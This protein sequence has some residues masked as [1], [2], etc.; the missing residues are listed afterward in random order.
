MQML[1][2]AL[3][4]LLFLA[5]LGALFAA[6][7]VW[8]AY[9]IT[10]AAFLMLATVIFSYLSARTL[11]THAAYRSNVVAH[12]KAID[13]FTEQN[14]QLLKGRPEPDPAD[15]KSYGINGLDRE[16]AKE[17]AARGRV[18]D[19]G[20]ANRFDPQTGVVTVVFEPQAPKVEENTVV[21][22]FD[23]KDRATQGGA[24]MGEFLVTAVGDKELQ[25]TP[26]YPLLPWQAQRIA[27]A[28][29]PWILYEIMPADNHEW[30]RELDEARLRALLPPQSLPEFLKDGK[31]AA[32]NDPPDRVWRQVKFLK[33]HEMTVD[34]VPAKFTVDQTATV[35]PKT[36]QELVQAG[37]AE[38]VGQV[39]VRELRSYAQLFRELRQDIQVLSDT[40]RELTD[41]VARIQTAWD[42]VKEDAKYRE[43]EIAK[44]KVDKAKFEAER[45][46]VEALVKAI[47]ARQ[48]EVRAQ[49]SATYQS[50]LRHVQEIADLQRRALQ[51]VEPPLAEA[52]AP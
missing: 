47:D 32:E 20:A 1:A 10:I 19:R 2:P 38:E 37:I 34:E 50:N 4:G 16:L 15:L 35:D 43:E 40:H 31:P 39:Y 21:F 24:Y 7:D 17:L 49:L 45:A 23:G 26:I 5:G 46:A 33:D 8:R 22:A 11:K 28:A 18:W 29:G 9:H 51:A 6:R 3:V 42:R 27:N 36:A 14:E 44:L 12:E 41:E 13:N 48:E 25:L 52:S 30:A